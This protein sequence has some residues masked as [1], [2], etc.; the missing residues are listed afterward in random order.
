MSNPEWEVKLEAPDGISSYLPPFENKS[1]YTLDECLELYGSELTDCGW[2][3]YLTGTYSTTYTH[4]NF[5]TLI[6]KLYNSNQ[7]EDLEEA[8]PFRTVDEVVVYKDILQESRIPKIMGTHTLGFIMTAMD[9]MPICEVPVEYIEVNAER[10]IEE[11]ISFCKKILELGWFPCDLN[12]SNVLLKKDGKLGFIDFNR[13]MIK[14]DCLIDLQNLGKTE[15]EYLLA[16]ARGIFAPNKNDEI[17]N[18]ITFCFKMDE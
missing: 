2:E 1:F 9:G 18:T 15:E 8:F 7:E 16:V 13:F 3:E 12:S 14:D 6:M 5:P 4:R 11:Y 17:N 10:L